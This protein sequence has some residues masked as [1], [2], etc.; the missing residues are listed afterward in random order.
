[1]E[2]VEYLDVKQRERQN[3][4][5]LQQTIGPTRLQPTGP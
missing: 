5:R 1:M 4:I 2:R 3:Q